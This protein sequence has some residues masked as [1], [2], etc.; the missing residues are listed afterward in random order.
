M[1]QSSLLVLRIFIV[2]SLSQFI[3]QSHAVEQDPVEEMEVIQVFGSSYQFEYA[4]NWL[5]YFYNYPYDDFTDA[6]QIDKEIALFRAC[7]QVNENKPDECDDKPIALEQPRV[8]GCSY[9][10]DYPFLNAC[11][12]HDVCYDNLGTSKSS[13]DSRFNSDMKTICDMDY[14]GTWPHKMCLSASNSYYAGVVIAGDSAYYDSQVEADCALW[15][16]TYEETCAKL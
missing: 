14:A 8:N 2:L 10:P 11:N 5:G 6:L 12:R 7:Q 1:L 15:W 16:G 13:C 4:W 3:P 9:S